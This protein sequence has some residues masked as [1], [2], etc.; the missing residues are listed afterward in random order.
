M[1]KIAPSTGT[2]VSYRKITRESHFLLE[3]SRAAA[4]RLAMTWRTAQANPSVADIPHKIR[5]HAPRSSVRKELDKREDLSHNLYVLAPKARA[6]P[7]PSRGGMVTEL[8]QGM[9]LRAD[10]SSLVAGTIDRPE[11][12]QKL[13][14]A[15][16]AKRF[17]EPEPDVLI[18]KG[19]NCADEASPLARSVPPNS[20]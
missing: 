18:R 20:L 4:Q 12:P 13:Q 16:I 14:F 2:T 9:Y 11:E 17:P 10:G 8:W 3:T 7:G 6:Q 1:T 15:G 5:S 19:E